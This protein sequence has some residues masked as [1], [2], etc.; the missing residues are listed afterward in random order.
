M[1]GFLVQGTS[2]VTATSTTPTSVYSIPL[3]AGSWIIFGGSFFPNG[4]TFISL[5]ISDGNNVNDSYYQVALPSGSGI[6]ITRGVSIS[7]NKTFYLVA[8]ASGAATLT[9][10]IMYAL[11]IG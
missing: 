7:S 5:S 2:I 9:S 1:L 3:T 6:N 10:T 11:R 4:L 8:Q